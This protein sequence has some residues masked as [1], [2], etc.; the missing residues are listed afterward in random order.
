MIESV[1]KHALLSAISEPLKNRLKNTLRQYL[2]DALHCTRTW[3]AWE[4]GTMKEDD[5]EA[6]AYNDEFIDELA[7]AV[8]LTLLNKE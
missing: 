5:F 2:D 3:D 8:L 4:V 7:N 6:I 1:E